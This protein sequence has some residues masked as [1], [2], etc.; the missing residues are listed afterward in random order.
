MAGLPQLLTIPETA[1]AL[2]VGSRNT[3]YDL[4]AQGELPVV[5]V[6]KVSRIDL[7]DVQA[8]I[9][10]NKSVAPRRRRLSAIA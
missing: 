4:I 9:D 10:R 6:G 3:V 2:G 5:T 8:Y 7:D 1:K